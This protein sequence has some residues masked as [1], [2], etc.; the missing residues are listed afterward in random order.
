MLAL[1]GVTGYWLNLGG[2][3]TQASDAAFAPGCPGR[4]APEVPSVPVR[5]LSE[6]RN[7][8]SRI[9]PPRVGRAYEMGTIATSNLWSDNQPLSSS[10]TRSGLV[11]AGYEM[12]WWALDRDGSQDDV[13][14][15]VLEFATERQADD[16]LTRA[17][18]SR[19]RRSGVG[20]A[21]RFPARA[22]NLIW[23]NPDDAQEWDV[24]FVR[25]HRLYRVADSPPGY[26]PG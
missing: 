23:V 13:V 19:C 8:V 22:S 18:S 10:S 24:L 17:A 14:A 1:V 5:T 9:M 21:A 16:A 26:L 20:L 3:P 12:R 4:G 2:G 25:A 15:D 7:A 6:L 11:P